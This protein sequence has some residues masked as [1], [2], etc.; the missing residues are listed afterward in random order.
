MPATRRRT[1]VHSVKKAVAEHGDKVG[2]DERPRSIEAIGAEEAIKGGDKATS[3]PR[4]EALAR[5]PEAR[6]T[7]VRP[8]PGRAGQPQ[9]EAVRMAARRPTMRTSW[10][11]EFTEVKDQK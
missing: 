10:M 1:L 7:H 2:A 8:G 11:R 9:G 4:A 5:P 3:K 6:R